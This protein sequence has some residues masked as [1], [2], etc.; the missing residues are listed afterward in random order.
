[1]QAYCISNGLR[2]VWWPE[3]ITYD[4]TTSSMSQAS[5]QRLRWLR[6]GIQVFL[7][8][9]NRLLVDGVKTLD[10]HKVEQY[11]WISRSLLPRSIWIFV[12]LWFL[13][14]SL[15]EPIE[16]VFLPWQVWLVV[17]SG[18]PLGY[19]LGLATHKT[20]LRTYLALLLSPAFIAMWLWVITRNLFVRNLR[21][22]KTRHTSTL[23]ADEVLRGRR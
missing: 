6:G 1:M 2:V 16:A 17:I 4:E 10:F 20:D 23:T 19:L 9:F 11:L 7:S 3:A 13:L 22:P 14:F 5:N 21:W 12:I 18:Y 8:Y 15:L